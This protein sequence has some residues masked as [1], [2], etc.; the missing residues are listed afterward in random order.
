M[1]VFCKEIFNKKELNVLNKLKRKKSILKM[2][3][4]ICISND[5]SSLSIWK[6]NLG[7]V[8]QIK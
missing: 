3:I 5:I 1:A 7:N 8:I 2:N 4:L 6:L